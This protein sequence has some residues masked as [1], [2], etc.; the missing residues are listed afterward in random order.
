MQKIMF[1]KSLTRA[2]LEGLKTKTRRLIKVPDTWHGIHVC[3][4]GP[5]TYKQSLVLYDADGA[6][7]EDPK[8]RLCGL[9]MPRYLV[10]EI[11]AVAQCY[12]EALSP[13]DW[14]NRLIYKDEPGWKNKMYVR[15]DLM[16]HQIQITG[17]H[18]ER[19]QDIS[20]EDCLR[21]GIIKYV[22][23]REGIIRY[24][25]CPPKFCGTWT[26][27]DENKMG[28]YL[29]PREAFAALIKKMHGRKVWDDNPWTFA[30]DFT[31][32]K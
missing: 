7:I 3:G 14:V 4:V 28:T 27:Y 10:G 31:R 23:L 12:E 13:L 20:D 19:L 8:T 21:E 22:S 9:I 24:V 2:V 17:R 15:A 1:T 5:D 11:V 25:C 30:Y 26:T 29:T 16:P 32:I 18:V 6:S